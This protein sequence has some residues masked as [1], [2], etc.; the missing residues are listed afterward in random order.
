MKKHR[1]LA[2]VCAVCL[3]MGGGLSARAAG[4]FLDVSADAW[5]A[6]AVAEAAE[7]GTMTGTGHQTFSPDALVTRSTVIATLWRLEGKP[8]PTGAAT[9]TDAA[10][11]SWYAPALAWAQA[12]GI[13][14]GDGR[15][16]FRPDA[17]VTRQELA[18]FLFRYAAYR[19]EDAAEG[20]LGLY[21]DA[22]S[23]SGWAEEGMK[24]AV[25]AGLITGTG[26]S[27]LD[28]G[29]PASRAQLAV[30]LDRLATPVMG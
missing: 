24:H 27:R 22:G 7:R 21:S 11:G 14:G 1:F 16:N 2:A 13:A 15:G 4:T 26:R 17:Y 25:G 10:A 5:Y 18:V 9:F 23:V 12:N 20:I 8:E 28:P 29:G 6:Q 30:I 3:C 19:G